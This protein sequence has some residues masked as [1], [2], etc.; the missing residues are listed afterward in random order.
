MRK[1]TKGKCEKKI[2]SIIGYT[3]GNT[4]FNAIFKNNWQKRVDTVNKTMQHF[5][6]T[7][8]YG[9]ASPY[10]AQNITE[11]TDIIKQYQVP[12][13]QLTKKVCKI[14]SETFNVKMKHIVKTTTPLYSNNSVIYMFNPDICAYTFLQFQTNIENAFDITIQNPD[15]T[16]KHLDTLKKW[17]DYIATVKGI[18]IPQKHK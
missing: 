14:F 5:G 12:Y 17:C 18:Q 3:P 9:D 6:Y 4:S 7:T 11:L 15:E 16:T 10:F 1:N 2:E 8:K 13:T